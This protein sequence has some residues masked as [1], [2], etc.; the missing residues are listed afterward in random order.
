MISA[1]ASAGCSHY[2]I[3][4]GQRANSRV[5]G[6]MRCAAEAIYIVSYSL[7]AADAANEGALA[8]YL[9]VSSQVCLSSSFPSNVQRERK[10]QDWKSLFSVA[11]KGGGGNSV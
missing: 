2:G 1:P 3:T 9:A 4:R 11:P 7:R 6:T 8:F 10:V 5:A